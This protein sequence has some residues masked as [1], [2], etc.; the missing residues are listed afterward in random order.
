MLPFVF[1][2]AEKL[3]PLKAFGLFFMV[4]LL[5]ADSLAAWRA[6]R[7]GHDEKNYRDFRVACL[8]GGLFIGHWIDI[9]FYHPGEILSHPWKLLVFW[10]GMSST[11]GFAGALMG[12]LVWKYFR[13]A[14]KGRFWFTASRRAVPEQL[15]PYADV[16][17]SVAPIPFAIGRMGCAMV[18]DHPGRLATPSSPFALAWPLNEGDGVHHVFGP[19]HIVTG[20]S[21]ARYDLGLLEAMVLV[22]LAGAFVCVWPAQKRMA[23]GVFTAI[24]CMSYGG[25][26]FFLDMLR[27]SDGPDAELRHLGLTFAQYWSL[28][29]VALGA[30]LLLRARWRPSAATGLSTTSF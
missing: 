6:K 9:V 26:R 1:L 5:V 18:H 4:G 20:G 21:T 8:L 25:I 19:L 29:M 22:V 27:I 14:R 7:I 24:A 3:G 13:F 11:G 30:F 17:C 2:D 15:L 16:N 10:E 23:T 28:A 12:T